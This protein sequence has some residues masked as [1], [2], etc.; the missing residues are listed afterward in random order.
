MLSFSIQDPIENIDSEH[1]LAGWNFTTPTSLLLLILPSNSY[2][3]GSAS[4]EAPDT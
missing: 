4:E 3:D 1:C 2:A